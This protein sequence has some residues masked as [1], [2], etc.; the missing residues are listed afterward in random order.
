MK[1]LSETPQP[2]YCWKAENL[3]FLHVVLV[4]GGTM[5]SLLIKKRQSLALVLR[6]AF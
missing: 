4:W 3:S 5:I 2:L 6:Y 1:T